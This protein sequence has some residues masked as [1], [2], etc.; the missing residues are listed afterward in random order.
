MN[1]RLSIGD[2]QVPKTL[3]LKIRLSSKP[4]LCGNEEAWGNLE[5]AYYKTSHYYGNRLRL[6]KCSTRSI[7][8]NVELYCMYPRCDDSIQWTMQLVSLINTSTGN[9]NSTATQLLNSGELMR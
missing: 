4:F 2:F 9:S 8:S 7:S 1:V 3:T 5:V 6:S